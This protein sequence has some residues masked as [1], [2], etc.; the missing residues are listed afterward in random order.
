L[1]GAGDVQVDLGAEDFVV[2][3]NSSVVADD[4]DATQ[5]PS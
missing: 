2:E 4:D 5:F 1:Q 3:V